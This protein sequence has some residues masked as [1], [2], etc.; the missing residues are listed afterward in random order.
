VSG[1][2]ASA[3]WQAFGSGAILVTTDAGRLP[4]ARSAVQRTLD[5]I[6]RACNRFDPGSE[7]AR[8]NAISGRRVRISSLLAKALGVALDAAAATDGAVDPTVGACLEAAG[9]DRDFASVA[10]SAAQAEFIPAGG[11]HAVD[12]DGAAATVRVAR[13]TKL[14]LGSTGKALA[15]DMAASAAARAAGCGVLFSLGGD[16]AVAG[17]PPERGWAVHV[18]DD[19]AAGARAPGQTVTIRSGAIATSSTLVRRWR[20]RDHV[21]HIVDPGTGAPASEVWCTV[22]VAA[23]SCVEANTHATAAIV[24]GDRALEDLAA[25]RLPA[26]LRSPRDEVRHVGGWPTVGDSQ[27]GPGT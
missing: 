10:G 17:E 5:A 21:H 18:T 14:D 2:L 6:N 19:H 8:V 3:E 15:V 23:S 24:R 25:L 13:G 22:S 1:R 16:L 7:L 26:R 20:R 27:C 4:D 12:F 11:W 9:Y